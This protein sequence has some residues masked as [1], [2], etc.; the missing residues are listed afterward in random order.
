MFTQQIEF[1]ETVKSRDVKSV[2]E[3][4]RK[5]RCPVIII[6]GMLPVVKNLEILLDNL[7]RIA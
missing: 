3:S 2:E 4:V 5:F 1:R 6:D 7:N